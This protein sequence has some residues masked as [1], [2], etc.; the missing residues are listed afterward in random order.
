MTDHG[1]ITYILSEE[2]GTDPWQSSGRCGKRPRIGATI[3]PAN[4]ITGIRL[5]QVLD[6]FDCSQLTNQFCWLIWL[7]W[8]MDVDRGSAGHHEKT[9]W[10]PVVRL[11]PQLD[12]FSNNKGS[13][14]VVGDINCLVIFDIFGDFKHI[15]LI[16]TSFLGW[17]YWVYVFQFD[18][19]WGFWASQVD[20]LSGPRAAGVIR[21]E[22]QPV[23]PSQMVK[24]KNHFTTRWTVIQIEQ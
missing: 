6:W 8:L 21:L 18:R 2:R 5:V 4:M 14:F 12:G 10:P 3:E 16:S 17:L 7:M 9:V 20:K 15:L 13:E 23:V 19:T 22:A 24:T 1:Q 11:E